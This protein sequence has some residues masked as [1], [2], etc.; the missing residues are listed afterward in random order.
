MI[1]LSFSFEIPIHATEIPMFGGIYGGTSGAIVP[2][3]TSS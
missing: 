2:K 3:V 1:F